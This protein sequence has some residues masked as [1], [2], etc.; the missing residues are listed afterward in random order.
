MQGCGR[1]NFDSFYTSINNGATN[2]EYTFY[3]KHKLGSAILWQLS[4]TIP[5]LR[6]GFGISASGSGSPIRSPEVPK[7]FKR[8]CSHRFASSKANVKLIKSTPIN[9]G[10]VRLESHEDY[11]IVRCVGVPK[12]GKKLHIAWS[13]EDADRRYEDWIRFG[14]TLWS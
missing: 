8:R 3:S 6:I 9:G 11:W 7:T 4:N 12:P 13:R 10:E 14:R 2:S 5:Q 1:C